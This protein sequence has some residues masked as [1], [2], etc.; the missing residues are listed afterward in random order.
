MHRLLSQRACEHASQEVGTPF[1]LDP[2]YLRCFL[3]WDFPGAST[4]P[5]HGKGLTV[6][7]EG[8][9]VL[10]CCRILVVFQIVL[11]YTFA[12]IVFPSKMYCSNFLVQLVKL[13]MKPVHHEEYMSKSSSL[14]RAQTC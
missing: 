10:H 4:S 1:S 8:F 7:L 13:H 6:V 3:F 12:N 14:K 9:H 11:H 5:V 2:R